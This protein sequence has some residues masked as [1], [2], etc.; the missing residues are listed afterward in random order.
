M[1]M[2]KLYLSRSNL[3]AL[4]RKLD[5]KNSQKT[6]VKYRNELDP[7][8]NTVDTLMVIAVEDKDLYVNRERGVMYD[9]LK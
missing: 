6:I 5:D 9:E 1:N 3:E 8:V 4:L 7:F 2:N